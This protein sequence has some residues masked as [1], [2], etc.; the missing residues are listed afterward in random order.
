M[1][2]GELTTEYCSVLLP[3]CE[4]LLCRPPL[5]KINNPFQIY[6][7]LLFKYLLNKPGSMRCFG[8][9]C[10]AISP[11]LLRLSLRTSLPALKAKLPRVEWHS[12][13]VLYDM[14]II[15]PSTY[16][17]IFPSILLFLLATYSESLYI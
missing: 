13:E 5:C 8:T 1:T 11:N 15:S 3:T 9:N 16:T 10:T 12:E 4:C 17:P 14:T 7:A 6:E 2:L